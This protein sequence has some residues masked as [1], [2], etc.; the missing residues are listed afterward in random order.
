MTEYRA[1]ASFGVAIR[2][3]IYPVLLKAGDVL[4]ENNEADIRG[5]L[6]EGLIEKVVSKAKPGRPIGGSKEALAAAQQAAAG[7]DTQAGSGSGDDTQAGG[8]NV[9]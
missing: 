1:K 4:P 5:L 3:T 6:A 7:D 2:G 8:D 9:E